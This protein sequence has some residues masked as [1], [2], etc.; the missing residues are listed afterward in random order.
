MI[1]KEAA[2]KAY[3]FGVQ[4]ALCDSGLVKQANV[5]GQLLA[6]ALITG[7]IGAAGGG[8]SDKS[9]APVGMARGLAFG[10]GDVAATQLAN[11]ILRGHGGGLPV[12]GAGLMGGL[13]GYK[14]MKEFGPNPRQT[15]AQKLNL[16]Q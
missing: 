5:P 6:E 3:E 9:T 2:Q 16:S 10:A 15:L 11:A 13:G 14:L 8:I 12:F 4:K 1:T 7:G